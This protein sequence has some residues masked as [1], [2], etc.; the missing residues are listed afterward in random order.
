MNQQRP[1][2]TVQLGDWTLAARLADVPDFDTAFTTSVDVACGVANGDSAHH[3][4]VVQCVDLTGVAWN[5]GANQSIGWEGHRLH[6]TVCA[7]VEGVRPEGNDGAVLVFYITADF[8]N[9]KH[10]W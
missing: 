9:V 3:L 2:Q 1:H 6:L 10:I 7:D 4:A 8:K 5:T